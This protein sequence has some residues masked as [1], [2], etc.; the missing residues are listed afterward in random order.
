MVV[1][2]WAFKNVFM[3]HCLIFFGY[4]EFA[5]IFSL[6]K[7]LEKIASHGLDDC[8]LSSGS[9]HLGSQKLIKHVP[10]YIVI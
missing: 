5:V 4:H 8:F 2:F 1:F 9:Y 7:R 10:S 3:L 6:A